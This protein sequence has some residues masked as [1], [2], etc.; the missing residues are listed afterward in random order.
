M[1]CYRCKQPWREGSCGCDDGITLL[2]GDCRELLPQLEPGSVDLVLTDP[3]YDVVATGAGIGGRRKYLADIVDFTDGGFDISILD[4]FDNWVCF[5]TKAQLKDLLCAT[6]KRRWMLITWNKPNPTPLCNSNYLPDT[7]YI[8]HAFQSGR[9]FGD[10]R[11]KSRFIVHPV[12]KTGLDHPNIKPLAVVT[13]MVRLGSQPG[14]LV[15]D[16]YAGSGT[17]GRACKDLGRKCLMIEIE[18]KYVK[19]AA[20]RLRQKILF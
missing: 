2:W 3:P 11:D 13:K 14:E 8:V 9:L 7:E 6:G 4:Q 17:T 10:Y 5:C 15:I 1:E 12:T 18:E 20:E 16:L 19:I